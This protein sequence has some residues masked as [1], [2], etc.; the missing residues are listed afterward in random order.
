MSQAPLVRLEYADV[1]RLRLADDWFEIH[2]RQN[3]PFD[4]NAGRDFYEGQP[5]ANAAE[6]AALGYIEEVAVVS[7]L[8]GKADLTHFFNEFPVLA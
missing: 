6:H 1:H 5:S 2:M 7:V 8:A 3:I 4:V